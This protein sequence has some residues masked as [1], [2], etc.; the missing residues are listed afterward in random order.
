MFA[1]HTAP[2]PIRDGKRLLLVFA[3]A[4]GALFYV[5]WKTQHAKDSFLTGPYN[6]RIASA[7]MAASKGDAG[8]RVWLEQVCPAYMAR[9]PQ[10]ANAASQQAFAKG[11][12]YFL[13]L[14]LWFCLQYA[15][16]G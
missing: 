6:G 13:P 16:G 9:V 7:A 10:E 2:D 3:L 14:G 4:A 1:T 15:R 12:D 8:A 11:Q 5:N